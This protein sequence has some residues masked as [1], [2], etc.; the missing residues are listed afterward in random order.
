M[1]TESRS[2]TLGCSV[3]LI[4][5]FCYLQKITSRLRLMLFASL[6]VL[7]VILICFF[8]SDSSSGRLLI[9][10]V[11]VDML[12]DKLLI[13]HGSGMFKSTY[14]IHQAKYFSSVGYTQKELLLADNTHYAFNDYY[15]FLIDYGLLSISIV[16]LM[17]FY[18]IRIGLR[19]ILESNV[20]LLYMLSLAA[21]IIIMTAAA[22]NHIFEKP[23][24]QSVFLLGIF[25]VL[26]AHLR[27]G[28]PVGFL[29]TVY[30]I[31][32]C[33]IICF[34]FNY[35]VF[36]YS[37]YQKN[38]EAHELYSSGFLNKSLTMLQDIYPTYKTDSFYLEFYGRVLLRS[39]QHL[40]ALKMLEQAALIAPN[41]ELLK[42]IGDCYCQLRDLIRS[43]KYYKLA[44][45]MVPNRFGS[46]YAL[47][48]FYILTNQNSAAL[49]TGV[50]ILNLPVKV[51]SQRVEIIL[52]SV[53]EKMNAIN[54]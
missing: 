28:Y 2:F 46:R 35:Q 5:S 15:Q 49:K 14:L 37:H 39:G 31:L 11:S 19:K 21:I 53:S 9:Y 33:G 42:T 44:I 38:K 50:E 51:P 25:L 17:S 3:V 8:K 32:Q 24:Y 40:K 16:L 6:F 22:F 23:V 13:G 52:K 26:K 54:Q 48:N 10:K 12:N 7:G 43:E 18:L 36:H 1:I 34:A 47:F 4:L 30:I 29:S 45:D 27:S 41:S 20:G